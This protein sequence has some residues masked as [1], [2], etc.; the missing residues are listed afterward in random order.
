MNTVVLLRGEHCANTRDR[1]GANNRKEFG[2][3]KFSTQHS[4]WKSEAS[5][6]GSHSQ[7]SKPTGLAN[8]PLQSMVRSV[9][10]QLLLLTNHLPT[11]Q[12]L[13]SQKCLQITNA[14]WGTRI[15]SV[16]SLSF[17]Q[18]LQIRRLKY[19]TNFSIGVKLSNSVNSYTENT[20]RT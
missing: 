17:I 15:F 2:S 18:S 13:A 19:G 8:T 12:V 9:C 7:L 4:L 20:L 11:P 16:A 10:L 14:P 3:G 5:F 6:L 1:T